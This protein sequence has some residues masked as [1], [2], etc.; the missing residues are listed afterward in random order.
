VVIF[1][2]LMVQLLQKSELSFRYPGT[3]T[4]ILNLGSY[5]YLGFAE[6]GG[7][8]VEDVV[9][10]IQNDG[11]SSCSGRKDLGNNTFVV[12]LHTC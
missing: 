3:I 8:C 5:N 9:Q 10:R 11:V 2:D 12:V 1:N 6:S 4:K 7:P